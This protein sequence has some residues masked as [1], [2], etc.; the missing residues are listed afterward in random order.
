MLYHVETIA[1]IIY[2]KIDSKHFHKNWGDENW[3]LSI[4]T[5]QVFR[6]SGS[7]S[8]RLQENTFQI[9]YEVFVLTTTFRLRYIGIDTP[10]FIE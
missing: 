7:V 5:G 2:W 3:T 1:C 6:A 10:L 9:S 4:V 8:E